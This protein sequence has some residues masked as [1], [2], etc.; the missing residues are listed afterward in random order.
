MN[1]IQKYQRKKLIQTMNNS[2]TGEICYKSFTI[3]KIPIKF[4]DLFAFSI[5]VFIYVH[6]V[7]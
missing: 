5:R 2:I 1:K 7:M 6:S 3:L 4:M